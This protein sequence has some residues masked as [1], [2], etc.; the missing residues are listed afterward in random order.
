MA[1]SYQTPLILTDGQ[2]LRWQRLV[3]ERTGIDLSQ[4]RSIL[5]SGLSRHLRECGNADA[6]ALFARIGTPAGALEWQ[7]LLGQITVKETS[8]LRQPAAFEL[9]RQ[10]L[11]ARAATRPAS[12]ELWSVGC[13]TGEEAWGLAMVA[14]QV[15]SGAGIYFGV[16]GTDICPR[17]LSVAREGCYMARRLEPLPAS[18]RQRYFEP[19]LDEGG[20]PDGRLRVADSLRSRVGWVRANLLQLKQ[21]PPLAMDIIYC[22]NVLVYF[23]RW[24]VKQ[25]ADALAAR[26]KPGGLLIL[27]PG[28]AA[29]W[30]HPAMLRVTHDGVSAW[31][32]REPEP[33]GG[34]DG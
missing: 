11:Q 24:R 5:Q 30:Q 31:R 6:D 23:R 10:H 7:Q 20:R 4:H 17:A 15:A 22:Q 34:S 29:Q 1:W 18:W 27:G 32:R 3:E 21:L 25:I 2:F 14:D 28:E 19:L 26:L 33:K 12:L 13:A 9:A 16:L 8:F